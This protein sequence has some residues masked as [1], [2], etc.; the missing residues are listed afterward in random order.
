MSLIKKTLVLGASENPERYSFKAVEK[1]KSQGHSVVAVGN[2]KGII[3]DSIQSN[4]SLC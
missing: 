1:L 2:K 4:Q 3:G